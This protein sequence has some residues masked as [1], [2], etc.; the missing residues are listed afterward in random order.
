[1]TN[2]GVLYGI[3]GALG[4]VVV[5][6]GLY[7]AKQEGAFSP[8]MTAAVTTPA[9]APAAVPAPALPAAKPP[10][11]A[12]PQPAPAAAL[13]DGT[14]QAEALFAQQLVAD[15][16]SAIKRGDLS[17][18]SRALDQ[19]ERLNPRSADVIDA[20]RELRE[21]Q[22]RANRDERRVDSL[23]ADARA[24]ISRHDY[25]AADKLLD[26]AERIDR[27]DRDVQQARAELNAAQ[28]PAPSPGPVRR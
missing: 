19:A 22:Q 1:M 11:A 14:S 21:A 25:P 12:A 24:A 6:G 2:T 10:V 7:I 20:R 5:G 9:P 4:V 28:R 17:S 18:A 27:G 13:P 26:Q 3:I 15:A 23:V 16:R 8:P